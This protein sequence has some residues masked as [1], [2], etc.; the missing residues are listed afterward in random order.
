MHQLQTLALDLLDHHTQ[1]LLLCLLLFRQEHQSCT[2]LALLGYGNTLKQNKLMGNLNHDTSTVAS[3][4]SCLCA[5]VLHVFQHFKGIVH[6]LM[7]FTSV[8]VYHHSYTTS[9]VLI[10]RLVK[11]VMCLLCPLCALWLLKFAM[12][13]IILTF[14]YILFKNRCKGISFCNYGQ[15]IANFSYVKICP[16]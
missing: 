10:V 13:H 4:V 6:Q 12:C 7:A 14:T 1:D 16:F 3:L 15:T 8:D 5:T 9:V 11:P 2:I